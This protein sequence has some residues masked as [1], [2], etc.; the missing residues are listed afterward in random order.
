M[1]IQED[2]EL[3]QKMT[4][5]NPQMAAPNAFFDALRRVLA[6]ATPPPVQEA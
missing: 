5:D 1:S 3:V 6:A 2:I 4:F